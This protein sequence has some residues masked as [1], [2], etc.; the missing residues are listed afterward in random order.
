MARVRRWVVAAGVALLVTGCS[1]DPKPRLSEPSE[2]PAVTSTPSPTASAEPEPW[3]VRSQA[4]A[5]AFVKHWFDAFAVAMEG[6]TSELVMLSSSRCKTCTQFAARL[7]SIYA[8]GGFYKS[9]GWRVLQAVPTDG[10]PPN[11]AH[12]VVRVLRPAEKYRDDA[13]SAVHSNPNS[14]ATYGADLQW[15]DGSWRMARL[16][17][18][19]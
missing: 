7:D 14:R 5:V 12:V 3:E 8:S 2:T 11:Q 13:R 15:A 6:D 10:L 4:G 19:Q 18:V 16:V 17:L 9:R 1:A